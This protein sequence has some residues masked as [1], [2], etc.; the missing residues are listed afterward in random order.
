MVA[1]SSRAPAIRASPGVS[2]PGTLADGPLLFEKLA[3]L[4]DPDLRLVLDHSG[5]EAVPVADAPNPRGEHFLIVA[6]EIRGPGIEF[7]I[8]FDQVRELALQEWKKDL[9]RRGHQEQR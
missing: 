2:T 6:T 7:A 1:Q 4:F 8:T 9:L 3:L 5:D